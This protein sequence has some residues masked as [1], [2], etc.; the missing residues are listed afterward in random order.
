MKMDSTKKTEVTSER[1][2]SYVGAAAILLAGVL[3]SATAAAV[4]SFTS[5]YKNGSTTEN[6]TGREPTAAGTYPVFI[7]AVGTTETFT[8]ASAIAAITGMANRGYVSATVQYPNSSFGS[9][10]TIGGRAKAIFDPTSATS[11][12][13]ALCARAKADCSKGIVV[14][15]FSQGSIIATL[16]KN[17]EPRVQAA[18]GIGDH[19]SYSFFNL[20][21]CM[22]NGNHTL[23]NTRL[24]IVN[25][26][27]DTFGGGNQN[28][29][30]TK[31]Q[32]VTG[33]TCTST[34][35]S[36]LQ[37][38]GSGWIIVLNGQ[39]SDGQA[40]H[41]YMRASGGCSG[42]QSNLDQGWANGADPWELNANLDWLTGF[43][44]K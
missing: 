14:G 34:S 44:S 41:C 16:A 17:T 5:T 29:V 43:T 9:C 13:T 42:S 27:V 8:N 33:L 21:S 3:F 2:G 22:N 38:N 36:C 25:G 23:S 1:K 39:V 15:G 4:D 7:Y 31:A 19:N 6:I 24:R 10:T 26:E 18:Y 11:A 37:S 40:D 35:T 28:A 32:A 12:V 20:S 30:R